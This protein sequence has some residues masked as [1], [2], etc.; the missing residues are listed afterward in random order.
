VNRIIA[1]SAVLAVVAVLVTGLAVVNAFDNVPAGRGNHRMGG[2]WHNRTQ[3]TVTETTLEGV[4]S[5]ADMRYIEITAGES[6]AKLVAP[7]VWLHGEE[8]V[9]F[10]KLFATDL[11]NIGD[12]VKVTVVTVSFTRSS[13]VTTTITYVKQII[14]LDTGITVLAPS[15][16]V[17]ERV[18]TGNT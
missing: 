13:G 10:F 17:R 12:R 5:D 2:P 15:P 11:L 4:I 1:F 16:A 18:S 6:A 3:T 8:R 7:M 9:T 14:D